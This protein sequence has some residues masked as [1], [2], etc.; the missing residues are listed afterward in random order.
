MCFLGA[1]SDATTMHMSKPLATRKI[2]QFIT[3]MLSS[4]TEEDLNHCIHTLEDVSKDGGVGTEE[5]IVFLEEFSSRALAFETFEDVPASLVMVFYTAACSVNDDGC[6]LEEP[7]ISIDDMRS[8]SGVMSM[9]CQSVMDVGAVQISLNFQFQIQYNQD[10]S[11]EEILA[12][13]ESTGLRRIL[14]LATEESLLDRFGCS[15]KN[16]TARRVATTSSASVLRDESEGVRA[17]HDQNERQ[18]YQTVKDASNSC[19][20]KAHARITNLID[21][22]GSNF[23]PFL[24]SCSKRAVIN[25]R[26][27]HALSLAACLPN[28][29]STGG[30]RQ[31]AVAIAQVSVTAAS[32]LQHRSAFELRGDVL[33]VL[34]SMFTQNGLDRF[35]S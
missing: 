15:A 29:Q 23:V 26:T 19:D 4:I 28:A 3:R 13:S 12:S 14:E 27:S 31:C 18:L 1:N 2:Q 6:D 7:R 24:L 8:A 30:A 11:I 32:P 5:F 9:F 22:G 16:D 17:N 33:H 35:L 10:A 21:S 20:Y 34:K 25:N